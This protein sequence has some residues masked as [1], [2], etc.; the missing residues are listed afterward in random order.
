M[1]WEIKVFVKRLLIKCN[2]GSMYSVHK[3]NTFLHNCALFEHL[4]THTQSAEC[5]KFASSQARID[6]FLPQLEETIMLVC[7]YVC[8]WCSK[9]KYTHIYTFTEFTVYIYMYIY[10]AVQCFFCQHFPTIFQLF[11]LEESHVNVARRLWG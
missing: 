6:I 10:N 1:G 7:M 5:V 2:M 4:R 3:K 8:V 11:P 9:I